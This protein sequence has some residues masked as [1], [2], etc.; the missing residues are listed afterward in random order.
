[1]VEVREWEGGKLTQQQFEPF[2]VLCV[3]GGEGGA[4]HTNSMFTA[5]MNSGQHTI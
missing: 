2:K 1:M 4:Q 5:S 3:C